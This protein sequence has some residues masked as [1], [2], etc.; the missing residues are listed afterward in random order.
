MGALTAL[1]IVVLLLVGGGALLGLW[2]GFVTEILSLFAWVA[3]IFALKLAH[4][5]VAAL[6]TG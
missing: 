4:A 1:D 3:A 2:R 5:P 6:L